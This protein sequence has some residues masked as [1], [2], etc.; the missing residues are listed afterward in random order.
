MIAA[1]GIIGGLAVGFVGGV[2]VGFVWGA[3]TA[4]TLLTDE[5]N[6]TRMEP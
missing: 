6:L 5:R 1:A 2:L 4:D 3:R